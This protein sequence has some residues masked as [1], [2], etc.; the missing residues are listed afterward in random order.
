VVIADQGLGNPA[1]LLAATGNDFADALAAGAVGGVEDIAIVLTAAETLP[2]ETSAY[3]DSRPQT[4]RYGVGGPA[5]AAVP[6]SIPLVGATRFETAVLV[7]E[8]FFDAPALVG[9][10]RAREFADALSGG[11]D[12]GRDGGP[13]LLSETEVLADSVRVYLEANA[14]SIDEVRIYGG[15][16][17][18][19]QSV[20]DDVDAAI[21]D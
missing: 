2:P 10:A 17:A 11:A 14:A 18:I 12:I 5:S 9:I 19:S 1:T 4:T 15:G 20:A 6:G 21:A 16:E 13:I 7:A 3:L 8:E